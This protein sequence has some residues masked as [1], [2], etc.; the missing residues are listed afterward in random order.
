MPAE[1]CPKARRLG[2]HPGLEVHG[3]RKDKA[4]AVSPMSDAGGDGCEGIDGL[5]R[6]SAEGVL[7]LC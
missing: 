3:L 2:G 1:T 6:G 7:P 4:P 5:A